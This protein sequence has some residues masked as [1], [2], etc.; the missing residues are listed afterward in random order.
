MVVGE[1]TP[2]GGFGSLFGALGEALKSCPGPPEY[3]HVPESRPSFAK[4]LGDLHGPWLGFGTACASPVPAPSPVS[5][6]DESSAA[7]LTDVVALLAETVCE[8]AIANQS[9]GSQE[10]FQEVARTAASVQ[11]SEVAPDK[12]FDFEPYVSQE[13]ARI[14]ATDVQAMEE[15]ASIDVSDVHAEEAEPTKSFDFEA[16]L[17]SPK[18]SKASPDHAQGRDPNLVMKDTIWGDDTVDTRNL[19]RQATSQ[20]EKPPVPTFT[21]GKS[22]VPS[23]SVEHGIPGTS[24]ATASRIGSP[25]KLLGQSWPLTCRSPKRSAS[26]LDK[27]NESPHTRL[28]LGNTGEQAMKFPPNKSPAPPIP[29]LPCADSS[30]LVPRQEVEDV[31]YERDYYF[32]KLRRIE[33]LCDM[34]QQQPSL[35]AGVGLMQ[36]VIEALY[37]SEDPDDIPR[38]P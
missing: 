23:R 11:A 29:E 21:P 24:L 28:R 20:A 37:C 4:R 15:G 13:A 9:T 6:G 12:S 30:D 36:P 35:F 34:Y 25:A 17:D 32:A 3:N 8:T 38:Y 16:Y 2:K 10:G 31:A 14:D 5:V 19:M 1:T 26:H 22:P 33:A 7:D 18:D 27:E